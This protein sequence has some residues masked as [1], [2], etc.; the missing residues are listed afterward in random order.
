MKDACI[1]NTISGGELECPASRGAFDCAFSSSSSKSS[2]TSYSLCGPS[3]SYGDTSIDLS[4]SCLE[5]EESSSESSSK[6]VRISSGT[7]YC[8]FIIAYKNADDKKKDKFRCR[9]ANSF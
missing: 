7:K 8:S 3:G 1:I 2:A 5:G 4:P 6:E 9:T